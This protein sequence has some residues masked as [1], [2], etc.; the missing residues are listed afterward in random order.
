VKLPCAAHE[1]PRTRLP[2]SAAAHLFG[3]KPSGRSSAEGGKRSRGQRVLNGL[4]GARAGGRVQADSKM[5][6]RLSFENGLLSK[7]AY[8]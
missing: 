5:L 6:V 3:E 2:H 1:L 4:S 8:L 7:T